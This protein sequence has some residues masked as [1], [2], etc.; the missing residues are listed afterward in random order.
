MTRESVESKQIGAFKVHIVPDDTYSLEYGLN[1]EPVLLFGRDR[2]NYWD[3]ADQSKLPFPSRAILRSI[4]ECD[5][6]ESI[7]NE[8]CDMRYSDWRYTGGKV[9]AEH[10]DW[11]RPRYFK[12]AESALAAM[13]FAEY[14]RAYADLKVESFGR[15]NSSSTFYLA[16][17][18]SEL[19]SYAGVKNA[20][21]CLSS[22]QSIL[23]GEVYGYIVSGPYDSD[24]E[25]LPGFNDHAE[26]CWGFIG[27]S[28]YC[29]AEGE[30]AA[31]WL[32][33]QH[34]EQ[35]ATMQADAMQAA[36]PDLAPQ[37]ETAN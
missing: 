10:A 15:G 37:Y 3:I 6:A 27:D 16:F 7:L 36:R 13:F 32:N 9:W 2:R 30:S 14:G 4:A 11:N 21:S 28:S 18:Q 19:D 5:G 20:K 17:W 1:D 33:K 35:I 23:D 24:D 31:E 12:T 8:L 25:P 29:M 26:S 34:R 22:L